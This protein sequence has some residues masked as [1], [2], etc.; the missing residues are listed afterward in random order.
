MNLDQAH[1]ETIARWIN[2]G[3]K[4]ADI[5]KRMD[6]ELRI[7][8]T[9]MELRLLVN[10]LQ[11]M[12]KDPPPAPAPAPATAPAP[13]AATAPAQT[14]TARPP[15]NLNAPS[16]QPPLPGRTGVSLSVDT[17][18]RPGAMVSGNV[19]FSDGMSATWYL[20]QLGRLGLSAKQPGYRP[21]AADLQEF[22]IALE[23]ELAKSGM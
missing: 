2:E 3:M 19:N 8:I 7:S 13:A 17:L 22:Q 16:P 9:Y 10:E 1:K 5:Q 15:A 4:L 18:T 11:V 14:P 21:S 23:S 20:D 12:P 6:T